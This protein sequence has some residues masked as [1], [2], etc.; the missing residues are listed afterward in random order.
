MWAAGRR[1]HGGT[2]PLPCGAKPGVTPNSG[3]SLGMTGPEAGIVL[4]AADTETM[5]T[6]KETMAMSFMAVVVAV[7]SLR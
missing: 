2:Y 5:A 7:A 4:V 6:A 3:T 1:G